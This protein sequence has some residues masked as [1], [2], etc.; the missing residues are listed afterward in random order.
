MVP[1]FLSSP[2]ASFSLPIEKETGSRKAVCFYVLLNQAS[3]AYMVLEFYGPFVLPSLYPS[4][5][6]FSTVKAN[7]KTSLLSLMD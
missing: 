7:L 6:N 1:L 2:N 3:P 4:Y 5:F